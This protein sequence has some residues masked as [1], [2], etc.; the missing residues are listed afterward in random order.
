[1]SAVWTAPLRALF[2]ETLFPGFAE[3]LSIKGDG[4]VRL[5]LAARCVNC[6]KTVTARIHMEDGDVVDTDGGMLFD[7]GWTCH[8]CLGQP[9]SSGDLTL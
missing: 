3:A 8:N 9:W 5:D 2:P 6:R 7:G 4:R 1:M